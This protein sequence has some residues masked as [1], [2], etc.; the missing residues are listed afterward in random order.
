MIMCA[1]VSGVGSDP[2]SGP[3]LPYISCFPS[4]SA[5]LFRGNE[6]AI[7]LASGESH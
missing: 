1:C 6:L 5:R 2:A 7:I 4:V 3:H